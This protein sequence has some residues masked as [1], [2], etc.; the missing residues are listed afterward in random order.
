MSQEDL[1]KQK[2]IQIMEEKRE[3]ERVKRLQQSDQSA[4]STYDAIH[5]RML[6]R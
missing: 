6:G 1:E 5:Q 3:E 2:K 4:F